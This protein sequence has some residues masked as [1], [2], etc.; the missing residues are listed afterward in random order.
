MP[1]WLAYDAVIEDS[2]AVSLA[3]GT[4]RS[5]LADDTVHT[6]ARAGRVL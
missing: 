1:L 4:A 5:M 3:D 6:P 2:A